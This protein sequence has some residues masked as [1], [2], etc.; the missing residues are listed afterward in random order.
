MAEFVYSA[1]PVDTKNKGKAGTIS[2]ASAQEAE[3][4]VKAMF[5]YGVTVTLKEIAL[6]DASEPDKKS[7]NCAPSIAVVTKS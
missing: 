1:T 4:Q 3:K 2:A 5:A 6:F 7:P